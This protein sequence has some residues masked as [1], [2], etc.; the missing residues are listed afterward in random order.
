MKLL[1]SLFAVYSCSLLSM[2]AQVHDSEGRVKI[3]ISIQNTKRVSV[4]T[5]DKNEVLLL[6]MKDLAE[7]KKFVPSKRGLLADVYFPKGSDHESSDF[8]LLFA[9]LKATLESQNCKIYEAKI[10][11]CG[12]SGTYVYGPNK[13]AFE[14]RRKSCKMR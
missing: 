12:L 8:K 1:L 14:A 6:E 3:E 10:S 11:S 5:D 9:L 4:N 2:F 13:V 7:I